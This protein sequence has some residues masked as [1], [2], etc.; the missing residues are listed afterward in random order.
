[1][2]NKWPNQKFLKDKPCRMC[3]AIFTPVGPSNL[4]CSEEC[5]KKGYRNV[6]L[7]RHYG[8]TLAQYESMVEEQDGQCAICLEEGFLMAEHHKAKLVVDHC[9]TGGQVRGLLCHNCNRA[10]GLFQDSQEIL[11]RAVEYLK[12]GSETIR[13]E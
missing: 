3:E 11:L 4:Y 12:K 2:N 9:H 10:L 13:K 1:M 6:Y 7:L 8:L 5:T